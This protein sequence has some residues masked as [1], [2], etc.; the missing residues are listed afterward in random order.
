M[1]SYMPSLKEVKKSVAPGHVG[2]G[3]LAG[4]GAREEIFLCLMIYP[5]EGT[6]VL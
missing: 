6:T 3:A 4:T 2:E 1:R 5:F